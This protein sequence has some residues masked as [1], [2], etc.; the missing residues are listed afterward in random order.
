MQEGGEASA[1]TSDMTTSHTVIAPSFFQPLTISITGVLS[2]LF[3][4]V[5]RF[6]AHHLFCR[7]G[8]VSQEDRPAS[9]GSENMYL[10][11]NHLNNSENIIYFP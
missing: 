11:L 9:R 10:Y 6:T 2:V 3:V 1:S 8:P 4:K 5:S 7:G